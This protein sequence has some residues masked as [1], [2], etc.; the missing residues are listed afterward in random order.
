LIYLTERCNCSQR[1]GKESKGQPFVDARSKLL[2]THLYNSY[3]ISNY[4]PAGAVVKKITMRHI[5]DRVLFVQVNILA[6]V[7]I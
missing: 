4:K 7:F 1:G 6:L 2:I 5:T 3:K